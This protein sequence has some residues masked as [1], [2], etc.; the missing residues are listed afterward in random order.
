M[1]FILSNTTFPKCHY[2][3][4][5]HTT[6]LTLKPFHSNFSCYLIHQSCKRTAILN[7]TM[8]SSFLL[9]TLNLELI[10]FWL[11]ILSGSQTVLNKEQ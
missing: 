11:S 7:H 10:C 6:N 8:I 1:S 3:C 9:G 4:L 2:A 5:G